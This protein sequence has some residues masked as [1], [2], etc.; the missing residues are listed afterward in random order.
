MSQSRLVI[1]S[2]GVLEH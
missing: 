1:E 2:N